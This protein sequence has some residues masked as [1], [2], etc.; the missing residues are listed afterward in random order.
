MVGGVCRERLEVL[1]QRPLGEHR[2]AGPGRERGRGLLYQGGV[3]IASG[4]REL[5]G[6]DPDGLDVLRRLAALVSGV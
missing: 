6:D 5:V 4:A 1:A 3:G 2:L